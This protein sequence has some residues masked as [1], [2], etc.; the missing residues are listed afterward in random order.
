MRAIAAILG[1]AVRLA[2]QQM[3]PL[4]GDV[5]DEHGT[6]V[7]D[8]V[9]VVW[10][11]EGRGF[12]C[13]DLDYADSWRQLARTPVDRS[14]HFGLQLPIGLALRVEVE[15]EGHAR[16]RRDDLAPGEQLRIELER[17]RTFRGRLVRQSTGN[18]TPG[19][20]RAR[21]ADDHT[22]LFRGRTDAE[23]F[24]EFARLPARAFVC[25]V[26]PDEAA[27]TE[28]LGRWDGD[29]LE[30]VFVLADGAVLSGMVF[31]SG[32]GKPIDGARVGDSWTMHKAVTTGADGRYVLR[33]HGG[34]ARPEVYARAAG[35]V[36]RTVNQWTR[37]GTATLDFALLRGTRVAG[38]VVDEAGRPLRDVYVAVVAIRAANTW[39]SV[40]TDGLGAFALEG[41]QPDVPGA[42]L[43][44]RD[45]CATAVFELPPQ[46]AGRTLDLGPLTMLAPKCVRGVLVDDNGK[47][48]VGAFVRLCGT[49]DDRERFAHHDG[50]WRLLS[51][52]V[53]Q[54]TV[55]TDGSGAFGFGD[56]APGKYSIALGLADGPTLAAIGIAAKD[57]PAPLRLV[58]R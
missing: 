12:N 6:P 5:V 15:H 22:E 44:R 32:T 36:G 2:A 27:S 40:R 25:D 29:V 3:S 14:G 26:A 57:D 23:G 51:L 37:S 8:A 55:R 52:C 4:V 19:F 54:R 10:R 48:V 53:G 30:H 7:T 20:L 28:W 33:G 13:L 47:P 31:D 1:I 42:L 58:S 45:G 34:K 43:L 39:L 46:G 35:F 56:V 49:N 9:V 50:D 41:C 38:V 21:D 17:P 18:G 16:W 24:F 11:G